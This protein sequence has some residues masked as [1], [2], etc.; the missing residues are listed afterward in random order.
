MQ[1]YDRLALFHYST[2]HIKY[3]IITNFI[4][5]ILT[6]SK[7]SLLDKYGSLNREI[8]AQVVTSNAEMVEKSVRVTKS[9]I[10]VGQVNC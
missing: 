6:D 10:A 8:I 5:E 4:N 3:Q 2:R 1:I 7:S 9:V